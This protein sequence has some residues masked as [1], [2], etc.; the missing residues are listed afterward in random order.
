VPARFLAETFSE[1][2]D[3]WHAHTVTSWRWLDRIISFLLRLVFARIRAIRDGL[4]KNN[5]INRFALRRWWKI[6]L[7]GRWDRN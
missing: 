5:I 1:K 4:W 3:Q 2:G 7:R 6:L